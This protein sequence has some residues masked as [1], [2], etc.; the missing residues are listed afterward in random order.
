MPKKITRKWSP[1]GHT[2]SIIRNCPQ[3]TIKGAELSSRDLCEPHLGHLWG[4]GGNPR[5]LTGVELAANLRRLGESHDPQAVPAP[6]RRKEQVLTQP[7]GD[8][9]ALYLHLAFEPRRDFRD[10]L[11]AFHLHIRTHTIHEWRLTH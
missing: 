9:S 10:F 4:S 6:C 3:G 8:K 1:L 7:W 5:R 2:A 11:A